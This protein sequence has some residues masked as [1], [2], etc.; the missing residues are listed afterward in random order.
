M[1]EI[2]ELSGLTAEAL[3]DKMQVWANAWPEL[4]KTALNEGAGYI[5]DAVQIS[6]AAHSQ[7]GA[8]V[9]AV[10]VK[11]SINPIGAKVDVAPKQQYKARVFEGTA[12]MPIQAKSKSVVW[13]RK[14]GKLYKT[15]RTTDTPFLQIGP[16]KAGNFFY[17]RPMQ[18]TIH[19][20]PIWDRVERALMPKVLSH[21][22]ETIV[23]G[24]TQ[25]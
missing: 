12:R 2:T 24:V 13:K 11:T 3:R 23:K 4:T 10:R 5:K 19:P 15:T 6:W 20:R 25:T 21:I 7:S 9:R 16:S 1:V 18:V 22:Q 17:G 8:L 14:K